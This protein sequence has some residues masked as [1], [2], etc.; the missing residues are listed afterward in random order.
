MGKGKTIPVDLPHWALR[1]LRL[2]ANRRLCAAEIAERAEL[3]VRTVMTPSYIPIL[4]KKGLVRVAAWRRIGNH[5]IPVFAR[6][7]IG[8]TIDAPRPAPLSPRERMARYTQQH[9]EEVNLRHRIRRARNAGRPLFE[10]VSDPVLTA[11]RAMPAA[12]TS[13]ARR[14]R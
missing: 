11:L 7:A 3:N 13:P 4:R 9:R 1:I 6:T 2:L 5:I 10:I 12:S 8:K 14:N